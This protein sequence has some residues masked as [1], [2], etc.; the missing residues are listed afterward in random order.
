MATTAQK[1]AGERTP[2]RRV[3]NDGPLA[4]IVAMNVAVHRHPVIRQ[5]WQLV[6]RRERPLG[7]VDDT[8]ALPP[9]QA[10]D[11]PQIPVPPGHLNESEQR[12]LTL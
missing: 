5:P 8:V 10:R 11:R 1:I 7:V 4:E 3:V 2:E 6:E 12:P 9:R